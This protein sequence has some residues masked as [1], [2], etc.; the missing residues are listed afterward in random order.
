[1]RIRQ[2]GGVEAYDAGRATSSTLRHRLG[3]GHWTQIERATGSDDLV[4]SDL[5]TKQ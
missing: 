4:A 5:T 3:G 1:V 2:E